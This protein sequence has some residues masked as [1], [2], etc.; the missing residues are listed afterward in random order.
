M[1]AFHFRMVVVVDDCFNYTSLTAHEIFL[2]F[3]SLEF[4]YRCNLTNFEIGELD[5]MA[6]PQSL[7]L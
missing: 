1:V 4:C 3:G 2:I 5:C 6:Y 7:L